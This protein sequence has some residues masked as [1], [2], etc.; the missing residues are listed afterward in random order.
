[1]EAGRA[2][3]SER[4]RSWRTDQAVASASALASTLAADPLEEGTSLDSF[5]MD[6]PSFLP[7]AVALEGIQGMMAFVKVD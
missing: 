5:A 7:L 4:A 2:G 3:N 1:M 6:L